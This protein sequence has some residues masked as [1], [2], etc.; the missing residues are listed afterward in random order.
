MVNAQINT[1]QQKPSLFKLIFCLDVLGSAG[2]G[3][4]FSRRW[5]GTQLRQLTET[6]QTNG[7]FNTMWCHALYLSGGAA[8]W[9]VI[10]AQD[11]ARYQ[12][13]RKL[14]CVFLPLYILF[15]SIIVVI[16]F[17]LCCSVELSLSQ[18]ASFAF[19]LRFS[20]PSPWGEEGASSHMVIC[21]WLGLKH[22]VRLTCESHVGFTFF[23][24][25]VCWISCCDLLNYSE[26]FQV[27]LTTLLLGQGWLMPEAITQCIS[28]VKSITA[29]WRLAGKWD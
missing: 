22:K 3:L 26:P 8:Q 9:R 5:E 7:I 23:S 18:P 16:F 15:M 2:M 27:E 24:L 6:S 19:F 20:F 21:C 28:A 29:D 1:L 25:Q 17:S 13:V 14:H 10:T 12:A 4:I 11:H